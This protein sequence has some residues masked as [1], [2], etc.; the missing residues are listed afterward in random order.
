MG[1]LVKS[2]GIALSYVKLCGR[3]IEI[4]A[5]RDRSPVFFESRIEAELLASLLTL[6]FPC[7][8]PYSVHETVKVVPAP[9]QEV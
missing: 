3:C 6:R 1:Y 5:D 2:D 4:S 8:I 7:R 9:K